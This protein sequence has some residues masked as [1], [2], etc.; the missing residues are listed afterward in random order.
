MMTTVTM[1]RIMTQVVE[2]VARLVESP[3]V[4]FKPNNGKDHY[5]KHHLGSQ[6]GYGEGE[7]EDEDDQQA[8]LHQGGQGL[9]Y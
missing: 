1:T 4:E 2:G 9:Q 6:D 3:G 5:R 7:D 8:D